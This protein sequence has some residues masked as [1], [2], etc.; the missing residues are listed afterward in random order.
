MIDP[1][2]YEAMRNAARARAIL[3]AFESAEHGQAV[4]VHE[5]DCESAYAHVGDEY[6]RIAGCTCE[7]VVRRV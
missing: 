2:Q 4:A 3:A 7:P 5:E 1:R 6:Q